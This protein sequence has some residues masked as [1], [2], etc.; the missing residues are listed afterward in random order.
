MN[1]PR[2]PPLS[3]LPAPDREGWA[4]AWR[5]KVWT[6]GRHGLRIRL[7]RD[8][9]Q[10][11]EYVDGQS[12]RKVLGEVDFLVTMAERWFQARDNSSETS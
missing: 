2:I 10:L 6:R 11:N 1:R 12:V 8:R 9:G 3:R 7:L 5:S 4:D